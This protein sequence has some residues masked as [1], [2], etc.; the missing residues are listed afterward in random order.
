MLIS[1][2]SA[3]PPKVDEAFKNFCYVPYSSLSLAARLKAARREEDIVFYAQGGLTI[4]SL[5]WRNEK[6]ISTVDWHAAACATEKRIRFHHGASR[7]EA[8][9]AHHKLVMDLGR[10]HSWDIAMD[11]D[12]QQNE[13]AALNPSHDLSSLDMAALTLIATRPVMHYIATSSSPSKRSLPADAPSQVA[14]NRQ[15]S[16]CFRYG[17]LDHFPFKCKADQTLCGKPTAAVSPNG[18]SKNAMLA[19]NGKY[20]CFGWARNNSCCFG[21]ACMNFHGCS[22]CGELNHGAGSCKSHA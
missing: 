14:R 20:F 15:R 11:Y 18:K 17:G 2:H 13:V 22:I 19:P 4:K 6:S 21:D 9:T 3:I 8:F 10:S 1:V 7:A 5:D 12:I 16:H